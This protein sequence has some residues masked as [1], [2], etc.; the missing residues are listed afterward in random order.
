MAFKAGTA[1]MLASPGELAS[2]HGDRPNDSSS[3]EMEATYANYYSKT[4]HLTQVLL[5]E[6][7]SS[8]CQTLNICFML[9]IYIFKKKNV[10]SFSHLIDVEN[11]LR[12]IFRGAK[13]I[14][15]AVGAFS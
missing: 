15:Y 12:N 4:K 9:I 1:F 2:M 13:G 8:Y 11:A 10:G 3:C 14:H 5:S 6:F 7:R